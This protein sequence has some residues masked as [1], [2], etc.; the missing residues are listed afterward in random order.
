MPPRG[1]EPAIPCFLLRRS[2]HS[3]IG[4]VEDLGNVYKSMKFRSD[5]TLTRES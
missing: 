2:N 3:A 5:H 4:T 1:I